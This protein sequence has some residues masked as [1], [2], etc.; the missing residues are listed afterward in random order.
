MTE[1][2]VVGSGIIGLTAAIRLRQN[3]KSVAVYTKDVGPGLPSDMCGG[4]AI[5]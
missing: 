4:Y 2:V 5:L 3:G 1:F